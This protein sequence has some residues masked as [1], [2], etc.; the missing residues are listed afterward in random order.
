MFQQSDK[1]PTEPAEK[2]DKME[3]LKRRYLTSSLGPA[4]YKLLKSY[5]QPAKI[6]ETSYAE[7]KKLM[8]EKL[9]PRTNP[10]NEQYKFNVIKQEASENLTMFMARIKEAATTCNFDTQY[11]NM[12]RNRFITGLRDC[13]IR[14][15]LISDA[16]SATA[17]ITADGILEKAVA[18]ENASQSNMAMSSSSVN[19]VFKESQFSGRHRTSNNPS[20]SK[21]S[22]SNNKQTMVCARCTLKGHTQANCRTRCRFFK[23]VGT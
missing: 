17:N 1:L 13:K 20:S 6:S 14:T 11:D 2:T 7:L 3:D 4:S 16:A 21:P 22:N 10:V 15:S 19:A 9:A 18:K 12:V 5:C 23:K 8:L